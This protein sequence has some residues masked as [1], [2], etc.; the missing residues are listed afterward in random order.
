MFNQVAAD[1]D[2]SLEPLVPETSYKPYSENPGLSEPLY[3]PY[4]EK[5]E[6]GS[7]YEPYKGM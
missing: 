7:P 5:P 6:P 1:A 3:K 2:K 4:A